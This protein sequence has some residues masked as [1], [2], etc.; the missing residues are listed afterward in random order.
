M[1]KIRSRVVL[2]TVCLALAGLWLLP[3]A[4]PARAQT[5]PE[6]DEQADQ[7][8]AAGDA[9]PTEELSKRDRKQAAKEQRIQEYLRKK[10]ERRAEKDQNRTAREA[11]QREADAAEIEQQQLADLE[12]AE[13]E[14]SA[15]T[16]APPTHE[17]LAPTEQVTKKSR[18]RGRGSETTSQ[19]PRALARAQAN[20]R[21]T[22]LGLDPTVQEYLGLIDQEGASPQQL[23]AFGSFIA[24]NGMVRDALEYY[25]VALKIDDGDPVLWVNMGTLQ[26]QTGNHSAAASAFG[27]ALSLDPNHAVA[28]YNLGAAL[29]EMN[30]Y[31]AAVAEYK[32]ALTLDPSLGD[33]THNPQ[34][35]NNELLLAVKLML[36][37]EQAGSLSVPHVRQRRFRAA[38]ANP[39][40]L[41]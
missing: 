40:P 17:T 37:Q 27:Q 3:A 33:P 2:C 13:A 36:Y 23:A 30:K 19:L 32:A 5:P 18:R 31:E 35:A 10:E 9:Q 6:H 38:V 1:M 21:A 24:Q 26:M 28:H 7:D 4:T 25:G 8:S 15:A 12:Q 22:E 39:R 16:P 14:K 34:A 41:V 29:D 20:I 11:S